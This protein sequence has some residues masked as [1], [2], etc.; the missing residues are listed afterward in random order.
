MVQHCTDV[1][2]LLLD[3][4]VAYPALARGSLRSL[5]LSTVETFSV[6]PSS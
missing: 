5:L 4:Q 1:I 2:I 3:L 6:F